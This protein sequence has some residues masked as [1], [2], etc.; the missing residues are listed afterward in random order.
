MSALPCPKKMGR[1]MAFL[2]PAL[3]LHVGEHFGLVVHGERGREGC[4][5]WTEA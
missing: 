2:F 1:I 3:P 4:E 5:D